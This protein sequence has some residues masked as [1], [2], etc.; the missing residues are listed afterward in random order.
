MTNSHR[1]LSARFD[2]VTSEK[3]DQL[4]CDFFDEV[5]LEEDDDGEEITE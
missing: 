5:E 4:L 1:F 3:A 2:I